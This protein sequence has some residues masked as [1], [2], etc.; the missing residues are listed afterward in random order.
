MS[1]QDKFKHIDRSK[2]GK[3]I[4]LLTHSVRSL[5]IDGRQVIQTTDGEFI[6][7]V[8]MEEDY[9]INNWLVQFAI[10]HVG[11]RNYF[12]N[13]GWSDLTAMFTKGAIIL[14]K[15]KQPILIIRK[16]IDMD[17]GVNLQHRMN[18][19]SR[20]AAH[21]AHVPNDEEV[22]EIVNGLADRIVELTGQN[23]EYDTLTAMIP[24]DYYL[25]KGIDPNVV[26]QVI[27][28]R[29]NYSVD[30]E[31][32]DPEGDLI[33]EVEVI[34][35]KN[36]RGE[37]ITDKEREIVTNLTNGDFIFDTGSNKVDTNNSKPES[38]AD[39]FDPLSD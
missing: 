33:K 30:G 29:D 26:K 1:E 36:A 14:N 6:E 20:I 35:Y 13:Q 32:I 27:Y 19:Y 17:L 2:H 38:E 12:D 5:E 15:D 4:E 16:F 11:D 10:G 21:A 24:Y 18:Y 37:N 28:I 31:P 25:S 34:L 7:Y 3:L 39:I 9:F 8:L 22:N 23:P